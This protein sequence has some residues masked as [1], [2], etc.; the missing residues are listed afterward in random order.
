MGL[1]LYKSFKKEEKEK[2]MREEIKNMTGE[3]NSTIIIY[4]KKENSFLK[5]VFSAILFFAVLSAI[6]AVIL[7]CAKE[8]ITL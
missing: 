4:E 2:E 1:K 5:N 8:F 3:E 7:F 6:A